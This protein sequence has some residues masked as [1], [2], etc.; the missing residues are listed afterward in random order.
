M[1]KKRI[2]SIFLEEGVLVTPELLETIN[3]GNYKE[4]LESLRAR[5]EQEEGK[6]KTVAEKKRRE[7]TVKDFLDYYNKKYELLKGILLKKMNAVSINKG[8]KIFSKTSIIGRVREKTG[9]GF[10]IEDV[11]GETEAVTDNAD[12]SPGDVVGLSGFFRE[13]GFFPDEITWPDIPLTSSGGLPG[14]LLTEKPASV[15]EEGRGKDMVMVELDPDKREP[16]PR[17]MDFLHTG[18]RISIL[19]FRPEKKIGHKD[20]VVF[21]KKRELPHRE[22][23]GIY[24]SFLIESVP[25]VVWLVENGENWTRNYKGI[26]LVSTEKGSFFEYKE[27]S[28]GKFGK[29]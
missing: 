21:L 26:L 11:T 22:E 27:E 28:G 3:E 2:L 25:D 16:N 12:F 24:T 18:R 6:T 23:P 29:I 20:F 19:A 10:V 17:L 15:T 9:R 7:A 13:G 5:S 1:N 8:R 14:I 4:T